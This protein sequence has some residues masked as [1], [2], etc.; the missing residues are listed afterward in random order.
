MAAATPAAVQFDTNPLHLKGD[1]RKPDMS[2]CSP[3]E[4]TPAAM[5]Q[6]GHVLNDPTEAYFE[7]MNPKPAKDEG[8]FKTYFK[9]LGEYVWG[10]VDEFLFS[11]TNPNLIQLPYPTRYIIAI[12]IVG[13]WFSMFMSSTSRGV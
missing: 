3:D 13:F 1:I 2:L 12:M 8:D 9:S 4:T 6:P 7:S 5:S 11:S 10:Q